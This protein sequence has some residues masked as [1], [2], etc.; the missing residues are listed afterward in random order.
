MSNYISIGKI[1]KA[2]GLDG[3]LRVRIKDRYID[4][5]N[6]TDV[7]FLEVS[8]KPIPF[9][10]DE[11][12]GGTD[13]I[14]KFEDINNLES[15]KELANKEVML[16]ETDLLPLA[17]VEA[18]EDS[19]IDDRYERF[20]G[21]TLVDAALGEIGVIREVLELPGQFLALVDFQDQEVMVPLHPS[22]I[23]KADLKKRIL[24]MDLPEGLLDL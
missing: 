20:Q 14:V 12:K 4:D 18:E 1:T 2:H 16:R 10:I 11:V 13:P 19:D 9:F 23:Q 15:A 21:F 6:A 8:G 22:L 17:P 3:S 7:V 5:F 24:E